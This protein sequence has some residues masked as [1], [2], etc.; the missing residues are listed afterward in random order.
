MS[1]N[2]ILREYRNEHPQ[3]PYNA[4]Y[5]FTSFP[6]MEFSTNISS[7]AEEAAFNSDMSSASPL[8]PRSNLSTMHS[9]AKPGVSSSPFTPGSQRPMQMTRGTGILLNCPILLNL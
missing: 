2:D 7:R 5:S 1:V 3:G 8:P 6:L 9:A 4:E